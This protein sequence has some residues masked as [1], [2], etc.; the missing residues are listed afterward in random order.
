MISKHYRLSWFLVLDHILMG[1][2]FTF[3]NSSVIFIMKND[4]CA[5]LNVLVSPAWAAKKF[6]LGLVSR[7]WVVW[8]YEFFRIN[9]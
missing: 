6:S 4:I 1:S 9:A 3:L 7:I 5:L 2:I 8:Y